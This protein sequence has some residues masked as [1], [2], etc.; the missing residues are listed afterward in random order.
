MINPPA[1]NKRSHWLGESPA[2]GAEEW[3][4]QATERPGSWWPLW[5]EWLAG[6]AGKRRGARVRLGNKHHAPTEPAPGRYV[7]EKAA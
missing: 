6:F 1:K 7:K 4:A 3:L 5:S 2:A